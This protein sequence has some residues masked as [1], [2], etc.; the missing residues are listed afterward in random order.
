MNLTL[1]LRK[2]VWTEKRES[3]RLDMECPVEVQVLKKQLF[4]KKKVGYPRSGVMLKPSRLG[5]RLSMDKAIEK[6]TPVAVDVDITY[7]G[8]E[9]ICHLEGKIVWSEFSGKSRRFEHGVLLTGKGHDTSKW[10]QF[11]LSRLRE[12]DPDYSK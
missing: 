1:K 8:G 6:D 7:L 4:G 10:E 9:K 12:H 5:M 3:I 11:M 2:A